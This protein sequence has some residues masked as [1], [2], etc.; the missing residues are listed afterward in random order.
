GALSADPRVPPGRPVSGR[1]RLG[2]EGTHRLGPGHRGGSGDHRR[3]PPRPA[4]R[5]PA[6]PGH[7]SKEPPTMTTADVS[8]SL[9]GAEEAGRLVL[10]SY[11]RP[12]PGL[13]PPP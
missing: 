11:Q 12:A 1:V 5:A 4:G 2:R 10:P 3:A 8:A 13:D 6:F 9:A 7:A